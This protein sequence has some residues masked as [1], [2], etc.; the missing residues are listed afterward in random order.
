MDKFLIK[1]LLP[2]GEEVGY[3]HDDVQC[4]LGPRARAKVYSCCS[5]E[6]RINAVRKAFESVWNSS[7]EEYRSHTRWKR[8]TLN[9]IRIVAVPV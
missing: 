4:S 9:Q 3:I 2:Y 8:A 6:E 5:R 1:F 7:G